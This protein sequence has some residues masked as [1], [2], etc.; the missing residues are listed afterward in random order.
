V[1]SALLGLLAGTLTT[2]SPCVVPILPIVL[3]GAAGQ[4]RYG[5]L[6]LVA[7]LVL[8]FTGV[9]LL[10]SGA[11]WAL[12]IPG[13][14]IRTASAT[15]LALFGLML[16]STM[17]QERFASLA[18]PVSGFLYNV[19]ARFSPQGLQG[20]FLLG[21]LLGAVWTPCTGPTLGATIALAA[22]TDTLPKAALIMMMFSIGA[23]VPL[24]A[25]AYGSRQTLKTRRAALE[26]AGRIATPV[27]G[28]VLVSLG[29]L[30]LLGY[31]RTLEAIFVRA[32]PDRLRSAAAAGWRSAPAADI[33][34][35]MPQ[36]RFPCSG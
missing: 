34:R 16:L 24:L 25:L 13:E 7:G 26:R 4:H 8:A 1:G 12:D 30:V 9:G 29:I 10:I 28:A 6:A 31:D 17:L 35:S 3:V 11:A 22:S 18:A 33:D 23:S 15:L 20:Q 19:S 27:L 2:L 36:N 5:P 32:M 14:A 21:A